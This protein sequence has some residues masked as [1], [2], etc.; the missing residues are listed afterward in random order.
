MK[1]SWPKRIP[2]QSESLFNVDNKPQVIFH[3]KD[4]RKQDKPHLSEISTKAN[5]K[6]LISGRMIIKS[7]SQ[8]LRMSSLRRSLLWNCFFIAV[9]VLMA[10]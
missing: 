2:Q 8:P 4:S 3:Y 10:S 1:S 5:Y 6:N 9:I 7:A